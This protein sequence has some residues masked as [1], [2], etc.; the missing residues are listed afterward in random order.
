VAARLKLIRTKN[1]APLLDIAWKALQQAL[2]LEENA[3][4]IY[5]EMGIIA[6]YRKDFKR[7]E[8]YYLKASSISP[9]WAIPWSNL[10]G[11]YTSIGKLDKGKEAAQKAMALQP[12]FQNSLVNYGI[13]SEKKGQ[14]L[15]AEEY[16]RKSIAVNDRHYLPFERLGILF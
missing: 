1:P 6:E 2:K 4:Y 7:A 13:L 9:N 14:L 11:L 15:T 10:I 3:A 5:N 16:F 8:K 12:D